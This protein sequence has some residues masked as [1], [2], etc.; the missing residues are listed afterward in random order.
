MN[1][2]HEQTVEDLQLKLD[3]ALRLLQLEASGN[4]YSVTKIKKGAAIDM[5]VDQEDCI[6]VDVG[7]NRGSG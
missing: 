6:V 1:D 5:Q 3:E 4:T 2:K 7:R